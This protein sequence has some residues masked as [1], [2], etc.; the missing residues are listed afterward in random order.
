VGAHKEQ[1]SNRTI[2]QKRECE[3]VM[4]LSIAG[5]LVDDELGGNESRYMANGQQ[6]QVDRW[7][8][9]EELADLWDAGAVCTH[10][11]NP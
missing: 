11:G 3:S 6:W 2:R 9:Y 5:V 8:A 7:R 10:L 4:D 1:L